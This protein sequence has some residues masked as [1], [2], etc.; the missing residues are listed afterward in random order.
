MKAVV[1]LIINELMEM[2][3]MHSYQRVFPI[4]DDHTYSKELKPLKLR[5]L[6]G[7]KLQ[8]QE[9]LLQGPESQNKLT[10]PNFKN[11]GNCTA[12]DHLRSH[13]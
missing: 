3:G 4:E 5:L 12:A 7:V 9:V 8:L 10:E 11:V 1:L 6:K 2:K 13:I